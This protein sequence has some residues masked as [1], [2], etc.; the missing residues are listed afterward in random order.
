MDQA[1]ADMMKKAGL[2]RR[3]QIKIFSRN[4]LPEFM[5]WLDDVALK[6]TPAHKEAL[7]AIHPNNAGS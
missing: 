6:Q 1:M 7:A 5:K 3:F 2:G 4:S